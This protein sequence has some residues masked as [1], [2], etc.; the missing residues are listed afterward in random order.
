MLRSLGG[1]R[2]G[3]AEPAAPRPATDRER[4]GASLRAANERTLA[5]SRATG[6]LDRPP[7]PVP[8]CAARASPAGRR[9]TARARRSTTA[10]CR[11]RTS[12]CARN[13]RKERAG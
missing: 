4:L 2:E 12:C 8:G 7:L 6:E 3:E 10:R 1:G 13:R 9:E 11:T 5:T